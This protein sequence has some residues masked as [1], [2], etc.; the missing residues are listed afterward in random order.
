MFSLV[1]EHGQI[2]SLVFIQYLFAL[3][4]VHSIHSLPGYENFPIHIKWPN[5]IYVKSIDG[6]LIKVG[7]ILVTSS[8]EKGVFKLV[9]GCGLNVQNAAPTV[10]LLQIAQQYNLSQDINEKL[11]LEGILAVILSHFEQMYDFFLQEGSFS[12]FLPLYHSLWLHSYVFY[13]SIN[14]NND[15]NQQVVVESEEK[16]QIKCMIRGLDQETGYLQAQLHSTGEILLLQPDGN[17]FD[18]MKGLISKKEQ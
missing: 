2:Q 6:K 5:D 1:I 11:S 7:G 16:G 14:C 4:V 15:R 8:F 12:S 9:I 17:S 3:A 18:M 13:I 10:S